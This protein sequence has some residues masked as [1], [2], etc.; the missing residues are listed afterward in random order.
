MSQ[1]GTFSMRT[2]LQ[3]S[4]VIAGRRNAEWP[5]CGHLRRLNRRG[6]GPIRRNISPRRVGYKH[7]EVDAYRD[8]K[9][10]QMP[11]KHKSAR[12]AEQRSP[13]FAVRQNVRL[14]ARTALPDL[15]LIRLPASDGARTQVSTSADKL[16][17]R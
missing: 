17:L 9:P 11:K 12:T 13:T 3:Q 14:A 2:R 10:L 7:S 1:L 8:R 16:A 6:E 4:P 5:L 15:R